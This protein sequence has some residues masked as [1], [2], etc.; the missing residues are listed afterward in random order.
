MKSSKAASQPRKILTLSAGN[1]VRGIMLE[2]YINAVAGN[3]WQAYSAGLEPVGAVHPLTTLVL[4]EAGIIWPA[5]SKSWEEFMGPD[6]P[7]M[8]VVATVCPMSAGMSPPD[9]P[10][11]PLILNWP[12]SHPAE[13]AATAEERVAQFRAVF[14]IVKAKADAFLTEMDAAADAASGRSAA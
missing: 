5:R 6:A 8:D 1:A 3:R 2:A 7:R 4:A 13:N 10:G 9:W 14:E 12:L 11:T